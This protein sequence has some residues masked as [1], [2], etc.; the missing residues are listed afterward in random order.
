MRVDAHRDKWLVVYFYPRSFTTGCTIE[1]KLFR[2]RY[3][4]IQALGASVVGVS[5]DSLETQCRFADKYQLSFPVVP[6]PDGTITRAWGVKRALL[7]AA[8]RVTF[9]VDPSGKIAARFHHEIRV[10]KHIDSVVAFL[11]QKAT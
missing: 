7:D 10:G 5:I 1:S 9:V 8:K 4:E 2:D 11:K 3:E 6:D